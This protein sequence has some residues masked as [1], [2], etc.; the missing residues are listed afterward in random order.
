MLAKPTGW[1]YRSA[2]PRDS[3][4]RD[5]VRIVVVK[6]VVTVCLLS[7]VGVGRAGVIFNFSSAT[8]LGG[9]SRW[10]AAPRTVNIGGTNFERSLDRGLRYSLQGGSYQAYRDLFFLAGGCA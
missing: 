4:V 2:T 5:V 8:G 9:G 1:H 3:F 10:D 7:S 6:A